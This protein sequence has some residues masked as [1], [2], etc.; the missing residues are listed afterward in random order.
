MAQKCNLGHSIEPSIEKLTEAFEHLKS[1]VDKLYEVKQSL[2]T[3]N[4]IF[5]NLVQTIQNGAASV[6]FPKVC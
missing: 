2:Q 5:G 3:F 4:I 1:H 6:N